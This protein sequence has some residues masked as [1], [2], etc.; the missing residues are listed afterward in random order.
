MPC[1]RKLFALVD[2]AVACALGCASY[3]V[4][5][6]AKSG[7]GVLHI[8]PAIAGSY[9]GLGA[10]A[11]LVSGLCYSALIARHALF[12]YSFAGKGVFYVGLG[13]LCLNDGSRVSIALGAA[14]I[15]T[16]G[17]CVLLQLLCAESAPEPLI[18]LGPRDGLGR[19]V[20]E[21]PTLTVALAPAAQ[22]RKAPWYERRRSSSQ[23]IAAAV[24]PP[25]P[26]DPADAW[27]PP[28][29]HAPGEAI[30]SSRNPWARG[31]DREGGF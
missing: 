1:P 23:S 19:A 14:I 29:Q 12:L 17:V 7:D 27:Q 28:Q 9:L 25:L 15:A 4:L 5:R 21:P 3:L 18:F 16:G 26:P 13:G 6:D 31:D 22:A 10:L 8:A 24:P 30:V 20:L 2:L 11:V